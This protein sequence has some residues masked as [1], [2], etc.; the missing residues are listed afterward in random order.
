MPIVYIIEGIDEKRGK[1]ETKISLDTFA[2]NCIS[3]LYIQLKSSDE[4]GFRTF[5]LN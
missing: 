4:T 5:L 3:S 1:K 2:T